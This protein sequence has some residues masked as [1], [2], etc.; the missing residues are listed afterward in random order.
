MTQKVDVQLDAGDR[1]V[2]LGDSI[3]QAG[4]RPGG[5][6][7]LLRESIAR[8]SGP[9]GVE[10]IA[11]G[12]SGDRVPN[13]LARLEGD[14]LSHR[15]SW[16]V[17]YAGVNDVWHS[18]RGEGT[19]AEEFRESLHEIVNRCQDHGARVCLA[20]LG[21]IG[22]KTDGS[23]S[24]DAQHDAYS[25]IVREVAD[26]SD[27]YLVDLRI[28]LLS[29]L[30]KINPGGRPHSIITTDGVHLNALG[31]QFVAAVF[32]RFFGFDEDAADSKILRHIVLFR[33]RPETTVATK[34]RL[35]HSFMQL[36]SKIPEVI[37]IEAGTNNSPEGLS[38]GFTHGYVVTFRS[39]NDRAVYLPHPEH[40]KF[41]TLVKPH[42]EKA[43]VFDF[44]A[45]ADQGIDPSVNSF[46]G[47]SS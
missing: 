16:V 36:K 39:E 7:D 2:F 41:V 32:G 12:I 38:D 46:G 33:F 45:D 17:V 8:F 25:D 43:L 4:S 35:D 15:P 34:A 26:L 47:T 29:H 44:M 21:L 27:S 14:V 23:N 28:E 6:V 30:R 3:T 20:T 11:S 13:C 31:N 40:Q 24:F 5:Y 22:E 9:S 37:S 18:T 19:D 42:L 1:I 10:V